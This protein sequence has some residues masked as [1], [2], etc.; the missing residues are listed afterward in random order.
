M[1]YRS[2][3]RVLGETS[4]ERK[5][6]FLFGACLLLLITA[7]FWFYGDQTEQDRQR[8]EPE[9][10]PAAGGPGDGWSGTGRAWRRPRNDKYSDM[11][12]EVVE[13]VQQAAVRG[14]IH[15][16]QSAGGEGRRD[17]TVSARDDDFEL[18]AVQR[19]LKNEPRE[20]RGSDDR[21]SSPSGC[22]RTGTSTT[23]TS[24]SAPPRA[25]ASRL[26]IS[27][28]SN[29]TGETRLRAVR[30]SGNSVAEA[31]GDLMAV[32]K[33]TFST[34]PTR[35]S[36]NQNRAILIATAIITVFLAMVASYA[37]VRYVIVKPLRHLR[38][39]SDAISRGN[40]TLRA[41]IH[42][43]DEFE[44][45]AVAFNRMLRHL[46]DAQEELRQAN[47]N[48]D[49]KVDELAQ[50]NMRLYELN[51]LKSDFLATMSHELRTPLNS[52]LGFSEVLGSIDALGRQ[53]EALRAE[54]PEVGQDAAGD[55]Q[56][57]PRPGEDRERQDGDAAERFPHRAGGRGPVRHGPAADR[58]EEHRPGEPR[59]ARPAADAPGPGPR[60]AN[61]QQPAVATPSSSRPKAAASRS[62]SAATS[63]TSWCSR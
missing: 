8:A 11:V 2:I 27:P 62:R 26:A 21:T 51:M 25:C 1:S 40:T 15:P 57:H 36:I 30:A 13:V 3:K 46:T 10:G 18:E 5:C 4:L 22:P 42:T 32:A 16:S 9:H 44:E 12:E 33:L 61:P 38:D 56:R 7:S 54:H 34:E 37:I 23:T 20:V 17:R 19:F 50:A 59:R 24:R 35:E 41:D 55:D 52:I 48:L 29:V 43:G 39:V 28:M 63:R 14:A 58:T 6:R 53:A 45:L 60:A 49:G 31:E 47:V